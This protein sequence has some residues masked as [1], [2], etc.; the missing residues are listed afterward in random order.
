MGV[1]SRVW[2]H[3]NNR[4]LES[5]ASG[6]LLYL[7]GQDGLLWESDLL[8]PPTTAPGSSAS[9]RSELLQSFEHE[10][11]GGKRAPDPEDF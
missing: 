7:G 9:F 3:G 6:R 11:A 2:E 4:I 8:I 10:G 1:V 5:D